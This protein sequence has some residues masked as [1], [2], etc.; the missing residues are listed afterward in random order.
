MARKRN[1]VSGVFEKNPGNGI[2]YIRFRANGKNIRRMIGERGD[3]EKALAT[4]LLAKKTDQPMVL[5]PARGLTVSHLCDQ[6]LEHIQD[7][8]NPNRPSDQFSPPQ[9][10]RAIKEAFGPRVAASLQPAEIR[11]WLMALK[12][13][14]GTLNRYRSV[15]SSIYRYAKEE[16]LLTVNPVRD[17]KQLRVELPNPRWLQPG[18]EKAIRAVLQRWITL[19]PTNHAITHLY[20]RCHPIELTLALG[21]GLRKGNLYALR[22]DDHVDLVSKTIHL[23][24]SMT[25]TRKALDIPMIEDVHSALL[26]MR[27]IQQELAGLLGDDAGVE[28]QRMV[29]DGRVFIISENREWWKMAL[30]E[31]GVKSLRFHDLRHTF[32]SRLVEAGVHLSIVQKACGHSS[33]ATTTRYAHVNDKQLRD[34]MANLNTVARESVLAD[35]S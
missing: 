14:P 33:H 20:L 29:S 27:Q 5:K 18:E 22:W 2:W 7:E 12:L 17:T 32:A 30:A 4:I 25:K 26:E 9:R 28:R 13:K 8:T 1:D 34:A 3:A 19:C 15:F 11:S 6:Y 35:A 10:L 31:S 21:T 16:G 23:P 24:P